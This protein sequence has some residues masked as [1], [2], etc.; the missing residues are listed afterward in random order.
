M[1]DN[2]LTAI[3]KIMFSDKHLWSI[4]TDDQK[5]QH[6][7]I[8]NRFLSKVYP[9]Q[10]LALNNKYID[11]A[12]GMDIWFS[13]LKNKPYPTLF[14]SKAPKDKNKYQILIDRYKLSLEDFE[15]LLH[16]HEQEMDE[17]LKYLI[18]INKQK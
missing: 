17:E 2:T 4:V 14:W 5:R 7:F 18:Q 11:G 15:F 9:K 8:F 6:F 3:A 10:A 1:I 16:F 12:I 13:F